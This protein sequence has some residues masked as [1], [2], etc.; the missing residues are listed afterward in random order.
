MEHLQSWRNGLH[1]RRHQVYRRMSPEL[2]WGPVSLLSMARL[3]EAWVLCVGPCQSGKTVLVPT[4]WQNILASPTTTQTKKGDP[5]T[6]EPTHYQQQQR[7]RWEFELWEC[8]ANP[9][10]ESCWSLLM[11]DS[12]RVVIIFNAYIQS[13]LKKI[14]MWYSC[15]TQQ[16]FL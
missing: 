1:N 14:Q 8:S 9:K 15:F 4:S 16:Q 13:H 6:W 5:R 10:F 2:E 7:H 12:H 11:Q 3:L